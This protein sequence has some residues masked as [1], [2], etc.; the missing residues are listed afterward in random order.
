V[1][2]VSVRSDPLPERDPN[3]PATYAEPVVHACDAVPLA[4]RRWGREDAACASSRAP[5]PVTWRGTERHLCA[6]HYE[7]W[8]ARG[9]EARDELGENWGWS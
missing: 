8:H 2:V 9:L 1:L 3:P 4:A 7:M 6:M 5:W